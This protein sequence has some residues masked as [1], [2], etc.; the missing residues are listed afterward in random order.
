[1][2]PRHAVLKVKSSF[3]SSAGLSSSS[4]APDECRIVEGVAVSLP[5]ERGA[6]N[7]PTVVAHNLHF[8][9]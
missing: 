8:V 5:A 1:V 7:Q 3:T 6:H 4:L 9:I 2:L